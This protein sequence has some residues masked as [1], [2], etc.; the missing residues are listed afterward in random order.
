MIRTFSALFCAN[1]CPFCSIGGLVKPTDPGQ[2]L[3]EITEKLSMTNLPTG[4]L[5]R[6]DRL[7]NQRQTLCEC[8]TLDEQLSF[9]GSRDNLPQRVVEPCPAIGHFRNRRLGSRQVA[10]YRCDRTLA[11]LQYPAKGKF[12]AGLLCLLE[13]EASVFGSFVHVAQRAQDKCQLRASQKVVVVEE[14]RSVRPIPLCGILVGKALE[15]VPRLVQPSGI[16]RRVP[17]LRSPMSLVAQ[18]TLRCATS[19]IDRAV[20]SDVR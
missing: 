12:R 10:R 13:G 3:R 4:L 14:E 17:R 20:L 8:P 18:P 16:K 11:A 5:A 9:P 15:A 1:N 6:V 7:P 19:L 2:A